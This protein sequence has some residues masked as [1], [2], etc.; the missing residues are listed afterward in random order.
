M[1]VILINWP[2]ADLR[3]KFCCN[4]FPFVISDSKIPAF[5]VF[6]S[7][8]RE[9][10]RTN[11][12]SSHRIAVSKFLENENGGIV[13]L[14]NAYRIPVSDLWAGYIFSQKRDLALKSCGMA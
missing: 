11:M 2:I 3:L 10:G 8:K 5:S 13:M 1:S 7:E 6:R 12:H 9:I 4:S 14:G